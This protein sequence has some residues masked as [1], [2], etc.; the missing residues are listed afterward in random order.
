MIWFI[1]QEGCW[2]EIGLENCNI[3]PKRQVSL[4][5]QS[6]KREGGSG[7]KEK[8]TPEI[9]LEVELAG[10][11]DGLTVEGEGEGE[12]EDDSYMTNGPFLEVMHL[13][14]LLLT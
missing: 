12:I 11:S 2:V 3:E 13:F 1:F 10:L 4:L 5:Q 6:K 14:N 9:Y 8:W 7:N